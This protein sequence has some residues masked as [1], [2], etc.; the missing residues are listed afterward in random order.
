M[1]SPN[2]L[3]RSKPLAMVPTTMQMPNGRAVPR[4]CR[5]MGL[6]LPIASMMSLAVNASSLPAAAPAAE[7]RRTRAPSRWTSMPAAPMPSRTTPPAASKRWRARST[8]TEGR[9]PALRTPSSQTSCKRGSPEPDAPNS[10]PLKPHRTEPKCTATMAEG[11]SE[12]RT[13]RLAGLAIAP[14]KSSASMAPASTSSSISFME[15]FHSW[16]RPASLPR[17]RTQTRSP[18]RCSTEAT[19]MPSVPPHTMTS[20]CGGAASGSDS[21]TS[22][23][24]AGG[25]EGGPGERSRAQAPSIPFNP[26]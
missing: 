12:R 3:S 1:R 22:C 4:A 7:A 9:T 2:E 20:N 5:E 18:R 14:S 19:K 24:N 6:W 11:S 15:M 23:T 16:E 8:A 10:S 13:S 17:S 21:A 25:G 26:A